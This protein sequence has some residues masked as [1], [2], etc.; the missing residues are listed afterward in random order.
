MI[1][2]LNVVMGQLLNGAL[3]GSAS[4]LQTLGDVTMQAPAPDRIQFLIKNF[5]NLVV[6]ET[7]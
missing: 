2:G 3:R 7:E 1:V 5:A 6:S 4:A